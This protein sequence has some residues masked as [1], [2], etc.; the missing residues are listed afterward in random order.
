MGQLMTPTQAK[1]ISI[2]CR[3][4]SEK[5]TT[6]CCWLLPVLSYCGGK[7]LWTIAYKAGIKAGLCYYFGQVAR[8][9]KAT[10]SSCYYGA[11]LRC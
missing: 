7:G 3:L 2:I 9:G 10:G 1:A 8:V 5:E 4:V 11:E 6:G